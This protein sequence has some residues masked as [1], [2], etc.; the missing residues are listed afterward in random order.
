M[1]DRSLDFFWVIHPKETIVRDCEAATIFKNQR[2][3]A[4]H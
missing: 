1:A 3:I 2:F 4:S